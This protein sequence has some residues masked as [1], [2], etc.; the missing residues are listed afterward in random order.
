[1]HKKK[2]LDQLVLEK[3][4]NENEDDNE[5]NSTNIE[6]NKNIVEESKIIDDDSN[7]DNIENQNVNSENGDEQII[8]V[9]NENFFDLDNFLK[10][11]FTYFDHLLG[12]PGGRPT[13]P[14]GTPRILEGR[15]GSPSGFQ[16]HPKDSP[17]SQRTPK[18][19]DSKTD[20]KIFQPWPGGMG[21]AIELF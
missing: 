2:S 3:E 4:N 7:L 14:G 15:S 8:Y 5:K 20:R 21:E 6:D 17:S 11:T 16:R 12:L 10:L 18:E 19:K 13:N 9:D 1:M